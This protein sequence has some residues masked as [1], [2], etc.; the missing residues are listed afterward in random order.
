[1]VLNVGSRPTVRR[2]PASS[3]LWALDWLNI[4]M[5]GLAPILRCFPKGQDWD[6]G[7]IGISM[8]VSNIGRRSQPNSDW[9]A[10][11]VRGVKRKLVAAATLS[12][13]LAL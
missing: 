3:S 1:M 4:L 13:T 9:D 10:V 8:A 12:P 6:T 7:D 2:Q 11:D 5:T